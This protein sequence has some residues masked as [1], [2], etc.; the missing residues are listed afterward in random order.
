MHET[1]QGVLAGLQRDCEAG[2]AACKTYGYIFDAFVV[3]LQYL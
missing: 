3:C 1:V 2:I